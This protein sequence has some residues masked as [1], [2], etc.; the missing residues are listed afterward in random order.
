MQFLVYADGVLVFDS[1]VMSDGHSI[2]EV[3]AF[4]LCDV[5]LTGKKNL[6]LVL[7]Q[8]GDGGEYDFGAW[9]DARLLV[10]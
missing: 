5:D 6:T 10:R 1:G 9:A 3:G 7:T 2:G 8:A 4:K